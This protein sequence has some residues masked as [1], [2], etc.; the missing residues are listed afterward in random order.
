MTKGKTNTKK[1]KI[2][3]LSKVFNEQCQCT[4]LEVHWRD[5]YHSSKIQF[6]NYYF[7]DGMLMF[8]LLSKF[9][10]AYLFI[11]FRFFKL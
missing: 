5:K 10:T 9:A 6:F 3:C 1:S 7:D 11:Y 2:K 8:P 4:Y